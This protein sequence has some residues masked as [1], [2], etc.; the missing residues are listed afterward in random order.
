[1]VLYFL[2]TTKI[3]QNIDTGGISN[4]STPILK[5]RINRELVTLVSEARHI[6]HCASAK[7][8]ARSNTAPAHTTKTKTRRQLK[9]ITAPQLPPARPEVAP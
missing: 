9:F 2:N 1:V 3:E 7:P 4:T 8:C 6:E 5:L